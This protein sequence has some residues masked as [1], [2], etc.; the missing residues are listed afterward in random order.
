MKALSGMSS[1]VND[2]SGRLLRACTLLV[3]IWLA[4]LREMPPRNRLTGRGCGV[5]RGAPGCNACVCVSLVM[6]VTG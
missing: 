2:T 4:S 6:R 5:R 3:T 1:K